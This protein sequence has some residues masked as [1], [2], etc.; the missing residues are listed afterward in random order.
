MAEDKLT[1][2]QDADAIKEADTLRIAIGNTYT[3]IR[4]RELNKSLSG[5]TFDHY[6]DEAKRAIKDTS[7]SPSGVVVRPSYTGQLMSLEASF[8]DALTK[9]RVKVE[10]GG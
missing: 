3:F 10:K 4:S 2:D 6:I 8:Q 1:T 5:Y 7:S 9:L